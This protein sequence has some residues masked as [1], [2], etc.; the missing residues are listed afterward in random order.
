MK[1]RYSVVLDC[2]YEDDTDEP[3]VTGLYDRFTVWHI[4]GCECVPGDPSTLGDARV[5]RDR[6]GGRVNEATARRVLADRGWSMGQLV[7]DTEGM[8]FECWPLEA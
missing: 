1:T 5:A 6:L 7:P 8:E 3:F 4:D 2:Y